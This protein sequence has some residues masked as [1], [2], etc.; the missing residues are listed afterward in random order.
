MLA[1]AIDKKQAQPDLIGQQ[2]TSSG[3]PLRKAAMGKNYVTACS[4]RFQDK[5]KIRHGWVPEDQDYDSEFIQLPTPVVISPNDTSAED[6]ESVNTSSSMATLPETMDDQA[7]SD[8][9]TDTS[10]SELVWDQSPAQYELTGRP[11]SPMPTD[12]PATRR[13]AT[14]EVPLSRS[15]AFRMPRKPTKIPKPSIPPKPTSPSDVQLQQVSDISTAAPIAFQRLGYVTPPNYVDPPRADVRRSSRT[16]GQPGNYRIF[17]RTGYRTGK[18]ER[19]EKRS[20]SRNCRAV[21][22]TLGSSPPLQNHAGQGGS[23]Q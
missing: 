10:D 8:I 13:L 21:P 16:A 17:H 15:D 4:S 19:D 5:K 1:P 23:T 2:T 11:V 14:S 22:N 3:R 9:D 20:R 12:I 18:R 7:S 6:S